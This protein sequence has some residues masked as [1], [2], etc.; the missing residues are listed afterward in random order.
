MNKLHLGCGKR[1]LK[2]YTHIDLADFPHID[3][4]HEID[5]LP[6]FADE[7]V[8]LIYACHCFEYFDRQ[9]A[10]RVL[11]E[12]HRVLKKSGI[13]RLAV[14]DFAALVHVYMNHGDLDCVIGPIFGRWHIPGTDRVAYHKTI[15]DL[16]S[17]VSLLDANG[18][19]DARQWQP[20]KVFSGAHEGFDDYSQA[21]VPHMDKRN[22]ICISLNIEAVRV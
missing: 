13:L 19:V 2:G 22:G 3:Y 11:A 7:T 10:P 16:R 20:E 14:P 8:D 18:F 15:Y 6:M 17:L 9:E 21:Y 12:W 1:F 4:R 5:R